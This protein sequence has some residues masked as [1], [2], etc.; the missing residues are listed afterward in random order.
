MVDYLSF[1]QPGNGLKTYMWMWR[2]V[3]GLAF[4]ER[5]WTVPIEKAPWTNESF[6]PDRQRSKDL[7]VPEIRV[8]T[9]EAFDNLLA[10]A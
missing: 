8:S 5:I 10:T 9:W 2:D 3:H 4:G 7:Q 6:F 1:E